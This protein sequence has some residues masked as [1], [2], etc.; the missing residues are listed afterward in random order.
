M[1]DFFVLTTS[2]CD[3]LLKLVYGN[4]EVRRS[5]AGAGVLA[6]TEPA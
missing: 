2:N 6:A 3:G 5:V 4:D 1:R